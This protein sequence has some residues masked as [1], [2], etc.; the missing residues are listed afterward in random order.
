MAVEAIRMQQEALARRNM[1]GHMMWRRAAPQR[2]EH[3]DVQHPHT[4]RHKHQFPRQGLRWSRQW[5]PD[6]H[7]AWLNHLCV[8]LTGGDRGR[9]GGAGVGG[10]NSSRRIVVSMPSYFVNLQEG[11]LL[12]QSPS[13]SKSSI[14]AHKRDAGAAASSEADVTPRV[15]ATHAVLRVATSP[16]SLRADK[17]TTGARQKC[18]SEL[19]QSVGT[20]RWPQRVQRCTHER[21]T[22]SGAKK[23]KKSPSHV[24]SVVVCVLTSGAGIGYSTDDVRRIATV[25]RTRA[26]HAAPDWFVQKC[27]VCLYQPCSPVSKLLFF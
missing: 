7:L 5:S 23:K 8:Q 1:S 16:S 20:G 13:L 27:Q 10:P 21:Q 15:R 18:S 17:L 12:R 3:S 4:P 22:H 2:L 25:Y 11:Y 19:S 14:G 24:R 26:R 9:G 6:V